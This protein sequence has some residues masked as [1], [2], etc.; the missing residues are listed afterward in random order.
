MNG[1]NVDS[2]MCLDLLGFIY[3]SYISYE[4]TPAPAPTSASTRAPTSA[5]TPAPALV[6]TSNSQ[7][8]ICKLDPS[9]RLIKLVQI[10]DVVSFAMTLHEGMLYLVYQT[11]LQMIVTKINTLQMELLW[12]TEITLH[13]GHFSF[14]FATT[15]N[16][17]RNR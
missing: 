3:L 17:F 11:N 13:T 16:R 15:G 2:S 8:I 1:N 12:N 4:T 14:S 7:L 10:P 5:P 6:S 9:L